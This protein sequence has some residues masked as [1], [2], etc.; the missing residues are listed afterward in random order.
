MASKESPPP[1][2]RA[3]LRRRDRPMGLSQA[4]DHARA[5]RL[6]HGCLRAIPGDQRLG[7]LEIAKALDL[8]ALSL[9]DLEVLSPGLLES[10]GRGIHGFK[11]QAVLAKA[12]EKALR[13]RCSLPRTASGVCWVISPTCS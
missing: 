4:G 5:E 13:A 8:L 11:V 7:T 9:L 6:R 12:V 2:F 3:D 10:G 1:G